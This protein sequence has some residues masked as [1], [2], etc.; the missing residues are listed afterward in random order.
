MHYWKDLE[1]RREGERD[2]ERWGRP[3]SFRSRYRFDDS[4][5]AYFNG[6]DDAERRD[7]ERREELRAEEEAE[8]RRMR[9]RAEE[10]RMEAEPEAYLEEQAMR[11]EEVDT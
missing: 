10:R 6:Y 5:Q 3:D 1:S 8:E 11:G 7:R 4:D 9:R 2:F